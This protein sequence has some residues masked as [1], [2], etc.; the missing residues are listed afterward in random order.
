M[1]DSAQLRKTIWFVH[2]HEGVVDDATKLRHHRFG[3]IATLSASYDSN[4]FQ[5]DNGFGEVG[6]WN[7]L[8]VE[9]QAKR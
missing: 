1:K 8:T 3:S 4:G 2:A 5:L 9:E 7:P 6:Q